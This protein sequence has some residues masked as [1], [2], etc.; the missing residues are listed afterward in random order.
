M[1]TIVCRLKAG[2]SWDPII[3]RFCWCVLDGLLILEPIIEPILDRSIPSVE[4]FAFACSMINKCNFNYDNNAW[5][6]VVE[7]G[8]LMRQNSIPYFYF[9]LIQIFL[10]YT[11]Y[12]QVMLIETMNYYRLYWENQ[13]NML[14]GMLP[15]F[16]LWSTVMIYARFILNISMNFLQLES[17]INIL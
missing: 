12:L 14:I 6:R 7:R 10:N 1:A 3:G 8:N 2:G 9:I 17:L 15:S 5:L 13:F 11:M 16:K 4:Q